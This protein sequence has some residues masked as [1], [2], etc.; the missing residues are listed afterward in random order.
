MCLHGFL[1]NL[2]ERRVQ[3]PDS[4]QRVVLEQSWQAPNNAKQGEPAL[5]A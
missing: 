2:A 3:A 1:K 4:A 5:V